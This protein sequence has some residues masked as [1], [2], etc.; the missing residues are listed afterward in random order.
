[1][2]EEKKTEI[3]KLVI[4]VDGK[5]ISL[6][7]DKARK[8]YDALGELFGNKIEIKEIYRGY[9]FWTWPNQYTLLSNVC[10]GAT[11]TNVWRSSNATTFE[12]KDSALICSV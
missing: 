10:S 2:P 9:P 1:M 12:V 7:V 4:L 3:H 5:E 8:L 11:Q 6:P